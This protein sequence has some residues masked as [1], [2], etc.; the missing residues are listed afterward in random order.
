MLTRWLERAIGEGFHAFK[1][2]VGGDPKKDRALL[3]LV[4]PVLSAK[5]ANFRLRL[6]GNQGYSTAT[7]LDFM[8]HIEKMGYDIELFEQPLKKHDF[9]GYEAIR[10]KSPFP[11]VLDETVVNV[12]DAKR[13]IDNL[14]GDGINIKIAK[15]GIG[16]SLRI[17]QMARPGMKLM[18]GCMMET[19]KGLSAAMFFALGTEYFDYVDLDSAHLLYG[20][21]HYPNLSIKG[22][23][24]S[25]EDGGFR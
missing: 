8:K 23:I 12:E 18:I 13:A 2:K 6:D 19:M 22:P 15:S 17:A 1:L 16:Q 11:V 14:L 4:Y 21:K 24:I 5:L 3:R 10:G 7:Y 25:I 20:G 9:K